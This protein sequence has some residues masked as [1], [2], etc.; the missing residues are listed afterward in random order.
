MWRRIDL[1]WTDVSEKGIA[2]IFRVEKSWLA[3]FSTLKMGA[4][5]SSETS[6][7]TKCT[8]RQIPEDGIIHS[9]RHE[10]LKSY[11]VKLLSLYFLL[12]RKQRCY[13]SYKGFTAIP[14]FTPDS[15]RPCATGTPYLLSGISMQSRTQFTLQ[16][17]PIVWIL[18]QKFGAPKGSID[19]RCRG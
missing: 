3:D 14:V 18:W 2:S 4:I 5:S 7:H 19:F 9:H 1:V 13:L 12:C 8:R 16:Y 10:N 6:V 11:T 15:K 17:F